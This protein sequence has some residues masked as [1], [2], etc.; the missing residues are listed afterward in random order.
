MLR[1]IVTRAPQVRAF[2]TSAPA[3]KAHWDKIEP[4]GLDAIKQLTLQFQEDQNP[5]KILLG[6]G[7][8]RDD[9]GK[10]VIMKSVR[11]GL[12]LYFCNINF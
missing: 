3:L 1:K 4:I 8:Y 6:E 7:V 2:T 5:N 12:C 9:N 10:P 11:E